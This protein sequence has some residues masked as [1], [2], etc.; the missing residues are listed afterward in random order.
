M[1]VYE[2]FLTTKT[3]ADIASGMQCDNVNAMLYPFQRDITKWALRRGRACVFADCGLGKTPIQLAWAD[4]VRKE[5]GDVLIVAPLAVAAQTVREG[6]KFGVDVTYSRDGNTNG[7]GITITN[8]EMV[9]KFDPS[10]FAGVVLDESSIL[11]SFT[12]KVRTMLIETFAVCP[13]RLA[14]TATPS[15][16]DL[17]ELCNH[18]EFTGAMTRTEML[19]MF[20]VHDG[21]DTA[22]WRL[23]K[24]A[25]SDFWRWVCSWAVTL[26]TPS[27]LGHDDDGFILPPLNMHEHIVDV[28]EST[29]K[30][31]LFAMEAK[32]LG[33]RQRA[34][35]ESVFVRCELAADIINATDETWLIWCDRNAESDLLAQI[36][37]DAKAIKGADKAEYKEATML[38]FSAGKITRLITK[39]TISGFG[40][41]WQHCSHVIFVGLSDSYEQFYQAVRRSW[42]F[43]QTKPVECHIVIASTEGAVLANIH[44]KETQAAAMQASMV[45]H[46]QVNS[47]TELSGIT[48]NVATY[49][50]DQA[51]H[52]PQWMKG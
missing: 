47:K 20:F 3:I 5:A 48:R 51:M 36:V 40:M 29:D 35:R 37:D 10:Q 41:N 14:C 42:R 11:K 19:A 1:K 31:M 33:E 12:G 16:N 15:P 46:M 18:A 17:M 7:S 39:P 43:G 28:V 27:D 21:G 52:I 30:E 23:K 34:R 8:Y 49:K 13:Y 44:R 26:R 24:H 22:Q 6:V 2:Q 38:G 9:S 25:E 50:P 32:G 4:E 45:E